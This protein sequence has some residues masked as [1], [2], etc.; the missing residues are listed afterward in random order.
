M[1]PA[2]A[3][4]GVSA[5]GLLESTHYL[6]NQLL[7]DS[8]WASNHGNRS[9]MSAQLFRTYCDELSLQVLQ[10][11]LHGLAEGRGQDGL[12]CVTVFRKRG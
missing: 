5:A 9:D 8:D 1:I 12:D 7:P 11:K 2:Q 3:R 6:R 4:N 10:Q